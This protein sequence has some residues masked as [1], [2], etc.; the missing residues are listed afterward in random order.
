MDDESPLIYHE[1]PIPPPPSF[2]SL[3]QRALCY[4]IHPGSNSVGKTYFLL[5]KAFIG[6]G[7]LFLPKAFANGGITFSS[8]VL[9]FLGYIN[10]HAMLMLVEVKDKLGVAGYGEIGHSLFGIWCWRAVQ[11]SLASSQIGFCCAYFIFV[12]QTLRDGTWRGVVGRAS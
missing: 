9:L 7:V 4:G 11:T 6:T 8:V 5:L 2:T 10:L 12:A 1:P 3:R